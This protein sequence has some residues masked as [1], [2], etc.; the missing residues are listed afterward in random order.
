MLCDS[1]EKEMV[2]KRVDGGEECEPKNK[3]AE[4]KGSLL[5]AGAEI[6]SFLKA[7]VDRA[8]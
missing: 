3:E 2:S 4:A 6:P 5:T 7:R 8:K 1:H